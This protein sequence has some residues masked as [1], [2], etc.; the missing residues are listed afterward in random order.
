M[1]TSWNYY[2]MLISS[3]SNTE[4]NAA[5]YTPLYIAKRTAGSAGR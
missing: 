1:N 5:L 3:V 2:E 4:G